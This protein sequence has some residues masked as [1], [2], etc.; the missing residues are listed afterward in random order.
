LPAPFSP[1]ITR[2]SPGRISRSTPSTA[3]APENFFEPRSRMTGSLVLSSSAG[4]YYPLPQIGR[5]AQ[6]PARGVQPPG[7]L[8]DLYPHPSPLAEI[9]LQYNHRH[10]PRQQQRHLAV[11][12]DRASP[13]N[14]PRS[15]ARSGGGAGASKSTVR[16]SYSTNLR[17]S[18]RSVARII[19]LSP[20]LSG[21]LPLYGA[22]QLRSETPTC[23]GPRRESHSDNQ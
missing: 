16:Q 20:S 13:V 11:A 15:G 12:G 14:C 6:R 5:S 8:G 1:A 17:S 18:R 3:L 22:N 2:T 21:A 23:A 9:A 19:S 10:N 4:I 7:L